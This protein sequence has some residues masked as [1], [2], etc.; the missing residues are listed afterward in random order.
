MIYASLPSMCTAVAATSTELI[1]SFDTSKSMCIRNIAVF[2]FV[3]VRHR[4]R[5][6]PSWRHDLQSEGIPG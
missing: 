2:S 6:A 4:V 3:R 1:T 5:L